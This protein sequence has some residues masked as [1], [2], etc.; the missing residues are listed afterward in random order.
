[1]MNSPMFATL[2]M[3]YEKNFVRKDQLVQYV[4]LGK[5]TSEEYA[6]ITGD[7]YPVA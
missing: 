6:I 1:M 4:K 7:D 5:I 3:R 2:K